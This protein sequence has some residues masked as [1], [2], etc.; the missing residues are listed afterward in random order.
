MVGGRDFDESDS[1]KTESSKGESCS[2]NLLKKSVGKPIG[3]PG[4]LHRSNC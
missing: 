2:E 4:D 1:L 3:G